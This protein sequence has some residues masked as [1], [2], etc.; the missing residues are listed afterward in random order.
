MV[1]DPATAWED[2][3]QLI[4]TIED[5]TLTARDAEATLTGGPYA[6]KV[7]RHGRMPSNAPQ[8]NQVG[9]AR[10]RNTWCLWK[11]GSGASDPSHGD[12]LT[13]SGVDYVITS[14]D[15]PCSGVWQVEVMEFKEN[16]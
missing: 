15:E 14:A 12:Q 4:D 6:V 10:E 5:A 11:A 2:D 16:S 1:W 8:G 7:D 3:W 13:L 9:V